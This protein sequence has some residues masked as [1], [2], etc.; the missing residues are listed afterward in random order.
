[1]HLCAVKRRVPSLIIAAM[2]ACTCQVRQASAAGDW[3][4][5]HHVGRFHIRAEF[6]IERFQAISTFIDS[7]EDH[8]A[9]VVT[10][11]G[12]SRSK[13]PI[14]ID[15]LLN[16]RSYQACLTESAPEALRRKA[17]FVRGEGMGRVY[18]YLHASIVADLRH[19]VTHAILHSSL[20]FLPLWLDEGLAEYFESPA[21]G[22]VSGNPHQRSVRTSIR[23]PFGRLSSLERLEKKRRLS[24]VTERDY[25]DSWAWTH[26]LL[27]GPPE[28]KQLLHR[29]LESIEAH[30]PPGPLSTQLRQLYAEPEAHLAAH[31]SSW[32]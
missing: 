3:V 22:R 21:A 23:L 15:L 9:D 13:Q 12:L 25:R 7:L 19:E 20:P 5:Y 2:L 16:R 10:T 30:T 11:L 29:Y 31:F 8:E 6:R 27:H 24:A 17:A 18:V 1:M 4:D 28:A 26:F 14:V 32:K